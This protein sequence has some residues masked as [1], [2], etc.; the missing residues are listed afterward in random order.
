MSP[1]ARST[2]R[3]HLEKRIAPVREIAL[4]RPPKGWVK[5]IR[6]ALGM[7]SAQLANRLGVSQP[8]IS[9][10]ESAEAKKT[11]TLESLE[12]A[13]HALECELVYVLIPRK[14]L[15]DLV[16]DQ[17]VKAALRKL[18]ATHHTMALEAQSLD[19]SDEMEQVRRL[20]N[21]LAEKSDSSIWT[22][23]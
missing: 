15:D 11:I 18:S 21:A 22:A 1:E 7:T 16:K 13:A 5:A 17:S 2:A 6:E 8:R 19:R 20:A 4:P 23:R 10:L 12:N 14:P 3:R 9:V